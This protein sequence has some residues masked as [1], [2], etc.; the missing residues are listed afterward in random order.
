MQVMVLLKSTLELEAGEVE[1]EAERAAMDEYNDALVSAGIRRDA[2]GLYPSAN[3]FR[4][5]FTGTSSTVTDGPFA[6]TKE[7]SRGFWI[8]EVKSMDEAVKWAQRAPLGEGEQIE[9][10]Q[11]YGD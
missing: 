4:I 2:R 5:H 10:R 6:E 9:L 1:T 8:W 3:G 7:L 11:I